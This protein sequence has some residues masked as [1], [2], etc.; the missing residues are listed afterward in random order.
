MTRHV[1]SCLLI[2]GIVL[3]GAGL[4]AAG[5][6]KVVALGDS[7]TRGTRPGVKPE[8]TYPA[9]LQAGLKKAGLDGE[10]VNVGVGGERTDQALRRLDRA[11]LDLKPHAVLIMYGTNDSHVDRG[12]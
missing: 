10:L 8:E 11:V 2:L 1:G 3:P 7:I 12:T 9:Y 4:R 5:P 6:F